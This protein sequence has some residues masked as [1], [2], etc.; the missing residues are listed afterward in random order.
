MFSLAGASDAKLPDG[1]A[2]AEAALTILVDAL[3]GGHLVHDSGYLESGLTGSLAQLAICDEIIAWAR[4]VL[5][6]VPVDDETLALE[7]VDELGIDGSFLETE[8][9]LEHYRER[10]YPDLFERFSHDGWRS[11]GAK[12]L[13]ERA[14]DRVDVLLAAHRP[15]ET[16]PAAAQA[17]RAVVERVGAAAG[18]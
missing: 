16:D 14:A 15:P 7:L 13:A 6:P 12:T 2:A 8:H 9:T 3:S 11:R 10:W 17:I 18:L 5:A 4:R 1:Q